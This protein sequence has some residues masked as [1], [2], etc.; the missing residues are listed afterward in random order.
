M[1]NH[2]VERLLNRSTQAMYSI[3][4]V[5]ST[6]DV[7]D[8]P[9]FPH[10][11]V[12][13][14]IKAS[15]APSPL[16]FRSFDVPIPWDTL[17]MFWPINGL[18][19]LEV[20]HS[21][22]DMDGKWGDIDSISNAKTLEWSSGPLGP[23]GLIDSGKQGIWRLEFLPFDDDGHGFRLANHL[24]D[25]PYVPQGGVQFEGRDLLLL[26]R[27]LSPWPRA[28]EVLSKLLISDELEE[29]I[30]SVSYL[31]CEDEND[32]IALTTMI[33]K[34]A[35]LTECRTKRISLSN[36]EVPPPI[37]KLMIFMS[38]LLIFGFIVM[39]VQNFWIHLFMVWSLSTTLQLTINLLTDLNNP[40]SGI[41]TV[42]NTNYKGI[43]GSIYKR[44]TN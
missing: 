34:L 1:F 16:G 17:T 12:T 33:N 38:V 35:L 14:S 10:G 32:R 30:E 7:L 6:P 31:K 19:S 43:E 4:E 13:T 25:N 11:A 3:R 15:N 41:W 28:D 44:I 20:L 42:E 23:V 27:D 21:W 29:V 37:M 40:F 39:G 8:E 26:W 18:P 9:W 24:G 36:E 2:C 22:I 5:M